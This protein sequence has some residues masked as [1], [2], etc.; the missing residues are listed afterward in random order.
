MDR[1][2]V[3]ELLFRAADNELEEDQIE[4]VRQQIDRCKDSARE[5]VYVQRFL[6]IVKTRCIRQSAP[7]R[8]RLRILSNFPHR[9]GGDA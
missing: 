3:T 8:L 7:T 9:R 4:A 5:A 6:E 1:E 2:Q